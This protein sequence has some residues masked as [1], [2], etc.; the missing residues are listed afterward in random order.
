MHE[1]KAFQVFTGILA[2]ITSFSNKWLVDI[3][4]HAPKA[5]EGCP[6]WGCWGHWGAN[7]CQMW[8]LGLCVPLGCQFVWAWG[9]GGGG[10]V[11]GLLQRG[12][13]LLYRRPQYASGGGSPM[14]TLWTM[15]DVWQTQ[16]SQKSKLHNVIKNARCNLD[17]LVLH[18]F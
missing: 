4:A 8:G 12:K 17:H 3:I 2:L 15:G 9:L 14:A 5:P 13:P 11:W 1:P 6:P 10:I 7:H 16:Q 18:L